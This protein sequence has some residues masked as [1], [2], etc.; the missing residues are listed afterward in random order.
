MKSDKKRAKERDYMPFFRSFY[1][2]IN[3]LGNEKEQLALYKA[4]VGYGLDGNEPEGLEGVAEIMWKLIRPNIANSRKQFENGL[5][6][7][8]PNGNKNAIRGRFLVAPT[9]T[10]VVTYCNTNDIDIDIDKFMD[11]YAG[12]EWKTSNYKIKTWEDAVKQ[13]EE[14]RTRKGYSG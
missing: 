9:K 10:E 7:G 11:Y 5:K 8:A 14:M 6:G 4:I 2:A 12:R 13:W 3:G 1:E